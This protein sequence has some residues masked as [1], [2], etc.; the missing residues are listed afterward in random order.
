[1]GETSYS[2]IIFIG[3]FFLFY[4]IGFGS[5]EFLLLH[6]LVLLSVFYFFGL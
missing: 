2:Y 4:F 1:M 6:A 3:S 5:Y